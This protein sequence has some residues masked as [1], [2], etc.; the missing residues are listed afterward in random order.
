MGTTMKKLSLSWKLKRPME[1]VIL[2][3]RTGQREDLAFA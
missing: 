1:K 3:Q 2:E